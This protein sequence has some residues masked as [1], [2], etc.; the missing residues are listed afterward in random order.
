MSSHSGVW[1][2]V[3]YD[4]SVIPFISYSLDFPFLYYLFL[5]SF[6]LSS[7]IFSSLPFLIPFSVIHPPNSIKFRSSQAPLLLPILPLNRYSL[8]RHFFVSS[9]GSIWIQWSWRQLVHSV[10]KNYSKW[11]LK[12]K[13]SSGVEITP[14]FIDRACRSAPSPVVH[15]HLLIPFTFDMGATGMIWV[16]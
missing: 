2:F 11:T 7:P 1:G 4:S 6:F 14:C 3:S 9:Q 8:A 16:I 15:F 13:A 10:Y 5:L 12:R